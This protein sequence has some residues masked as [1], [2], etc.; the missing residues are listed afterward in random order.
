M[1]LA[2]HAKWRNGSGLTRKATARKMQIATRKAIA[3]DAHLPALSLS[4]PA[5]LRHSGVM[6]VNHENHDAVHSE[7]ANLQQNHAVFVNI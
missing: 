3:P 7:I 5:N 1:W 6:H 4:A 2:E